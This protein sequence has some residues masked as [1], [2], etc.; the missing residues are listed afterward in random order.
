V[1]ASKNYLKSELISNWE[2][3][4][5]GKFL[6]AASISL[7]GDRPLGWRFMSTWFGS[8]T[9]VGFYL[10][11]WL[12]FQDQIVALWIYF[13]TLFNQIHY[14]QSRTAMLDGFMMTFIIWG[15]LGFFEAMNPKR[16]PN[17][18]KIALLFSACMLGCAMS[19][20]WFGIFPWI[21]C[22][23]I[24]FFLYSKNKKNR[25][26]LPN[27]KFSFLSFSLVPFLVYFISYLPAFFKI[28][29]TQSLFIMLRSILLFQKEMYNAMKQ[30]E[31]SHPYMS[32]WWE[33]P[34]LNRPIW[35]TFEKEQNDTFVRCVICLGNPW[36]MW[37]G[38]L[39]IGF[40]LWDFFQRKSWRALLILYFYVLFLGAWA[41]VPRK[42]LF[43]YYYYPAA[44][45]LSFALAHFFSSPLFFKL[46]KK[47]HIHKSSTISWMYL[48]ISF[49]FF[50]YFVPILSA[51]RIPAPTYYIWMW[52]Q[53]WI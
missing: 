38:I 36:V 8:L 13:L 16:N 30:L 35:Y 47:V 22:F 5:L 3:P 2:H 46:C 11:G 9:L 31:S 4:P 23:G 20:K 43:Y 7:F 12:L 39:A 6:I 1:N 44:M 29:K 49:G 28:L 45:I 50:I 10:L 51:F 37:T 25:S 26:L 32:R 27:W 53:R 34:F 18:Q 40:C 41:I 48:G 15:L 24:I 17:Y 42:V 21:G 14:V 52:L 19:S 33:W